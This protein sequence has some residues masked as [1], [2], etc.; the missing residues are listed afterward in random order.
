MAFDI[1]EK[2]VKQSLD[3][4]ILNKR[5]VSATYPQVNAQ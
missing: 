2:T 4:A 1:T 5:S 3:T